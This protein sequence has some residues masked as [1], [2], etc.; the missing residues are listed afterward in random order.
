[1]NCYFRQPVVQIAAAL[2][3]SN[4]LTGCGGGN[5]S[6]GASSEA[7]KFYGAFAYASKNHSLFSGSV[8]SAYSQEAANSGAIGRCGQP[9]CTVVLEFTECGSLVVGKTASGSFVWG[10]GSGA[11]AEEA[12]SAANSACK[13]KG[14][15]G[16]AHGNMQAACN[17]R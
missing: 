12:H 2:L 15:L 9:G 6:E 10:A 8:A 5:D 3:L 7:T 4:T 1:M 13:K 11:T 14:G 16:C 17:K